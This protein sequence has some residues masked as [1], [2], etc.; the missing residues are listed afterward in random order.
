MPAIFH[1]IFQPSIRLFGAPN[2]SRRRRDSRRA[3]GPRSCPPPPGLEVMVGSAPGGVQ[4]RHLHFVVAA[5]F[6]VR[7]RLLHSHG[8]SKLG[9]LPELLPIQ[10]ETNWDGHAT[11]S[12]TPQ[13]SP[14]PLNAQVVEHLSREKGESRG[15]ARPE[16]RVGSDR[17]RSTVQGQ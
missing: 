12:Q 2:V 14:G 15:R 17:G 8:R 5:L 3:I 1:S 6:L 16:K 7:S 4:C 11:R 10:I 13:K 9:P